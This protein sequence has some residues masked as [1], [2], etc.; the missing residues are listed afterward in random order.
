MKTIMRRMGVAALAATVAAGLATTPASAAPDRA[1]LRKAMGELVAAGAAG[2]QVRLHDERG[3]WTGSAGKRT[4]GGWADVPT[5]G[6]FRVGSITKTFVSTVM[7]QLVGEG[8]VRLDEPVANHLPQFGLDRRITVRMT[9]QHTSGL[10]NYT[11]EVNPDGSTEPGIPLDG[12]AFIDRQFHTYQPRELVKVSLAKPPRFE[13]G[14]GWSYSNT[15]YILAG[16]LIE[17]VTGGGYADQVR[18]RILRQLGLRD[19]IIPGTW[20]GI[21]GPYAHGYYTYQDKGATK[22]V[23]VSRVNPTWASSAGE[24]ISTTADLDRFIKAL[25]TG[26]L[27]SPALLGEMRKWLPLGGGTSYGLGLQELETPCG[28]KVSGHTGGMHGYHSYLFSTTDGAKRFEFSVTLGKLDQNDPVAAQ[29]YFEALQ[30][31]A[32]VSVCGKAGENAKSFHLD[33]L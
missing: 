26:K 20:P 23:D 6:R 14:A 13:P 24:I 32:S 7:L 22:T 1:E 19:T 18:H 9:L 10:F 29:K 30:K 2:I 16:L 21:P 28:T 3:S 4:L 8:K 12:Q 27:L 31:V 15:N 33:R 11:G 17:K 5:D 25:Q